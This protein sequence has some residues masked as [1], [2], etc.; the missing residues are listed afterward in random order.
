MH[1]L[2]K[3]SSS[4]AAGRTSLYAVDAP[5]VRVR[6][7]RSSAA[8]AWPAAGGEGST[9]FHKVDP[10][11]GPCCCWHCCEWLPADDDD[12]PPPVPLP[13][14]YDGAQQVFY[15]YGAFCSLE[16]A[17]AHL[18]E[19]ADFDRGFQLGLFARMA[20]EV[21]GRT[22]D[23]LEAPPRVSLRRFGGPFEA[24]PAGRCRVC[25]PPFVSYCMLIEETT[26]TTDVATPPAAVEE[27]DEEEGLHEPP[28][29]GLYAAYVA[30]APP[31]PS[32]QRRA[33][34]PAVS[35]LARFAKKRRA[36]EAEE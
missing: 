1:L 6:T 27:E 36:A 28:P 18:L 25:E 3:S 33:P 20:R 22:D 30:A 29:P 11:S 16:C 32:P 34:P 26:T 13:K 35:A 19:H 14:A 31:P 15:V 23:V 5:Q 10:S 24:P 7:L 21:Y 17:K 9:R 12:S 2:R 4:V 8:V